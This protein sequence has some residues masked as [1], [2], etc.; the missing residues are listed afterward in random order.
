MTELKAQTNKFKN[1]LQNGSTLYDILPEAFATVREASK[2]YLKCDPMMFK[3]W[4]RLFY[5]REKL[6]R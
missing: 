3:L 1:L 2:E 5:L 6:Q 4:G